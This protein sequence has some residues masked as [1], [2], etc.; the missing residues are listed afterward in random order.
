MVHILLYKDEQSVKIFIFL[1]ITKKILK[2]K[3]ISI[4][5]ASII[6]VLFLVLLSLPLFFENKIIEIGKNEINKQLNG[7]VDFEK[8]KLSFIKNFPN[9]SL[10]LKNVYITG[11]DEFENDTLLAGKDITFVLNLKSIFSKSGYEINKIE[12]RDSKIAAHILQNGKANWD[13]FKSDEEETQDTTESNFQFKIKDFTIKN[14]N[15]DYIDEEGDLA[16]TL[17]NINSS[18]KGDFTSDSTLLSVKINADTLNFW[19]GGAKL[20]HSIKL[21]IESDIN[22]NLKNNFYQFSNNSIQIN[23]IPLSLNGWV[24]MN[25]NDMEMDVRLGTEKVDFKSILSLIPAIY[26]DSFASINADGN[27]KLSGFIAGKYSETLFPNF[28]LNLMVEN[29]RFQYPDLPKSVDNI[30][31]ISH[32][33]NSGNDLDN[34][35]IDVQKF[36]FNMA[37]NPFS[38]SGKIRTPLSDPAFDV[39]AKGTLNLGMIKDIYPLEKGTELNGV[40]KMDL[41]TAGKMSYIEQ[42]LYEKFN[43]IGAVNLFNIKLKNSDLSQTVTVKSG[44][45]NFNNRYVILSNFIINSD[46]NDITFNG[47]AENYMA[48]VLRDKTLKGDFSIQS[49]YFNANDFLSSESDADENT[50][51]L[52]VVKIPKNLDIQLLGT[53]K[54][55]IY[56]KM[57]FKNAE[58]NLKVKDGNVAI[59]KMNL[60]G[61]GGNLALSGNYKT[62]NVEQPKIDFNIALNEISFTDLFKQIPSLQSILPIFEKMTGK[63]NSKL[64]FTSNLQNDMMPVLTSIISNGSLSTTSVGLKDMKIF[65]ELSGLLKIKDLNQ[66]ILK[67]IALHFTIKDGN[68]TTKP[69]DI[70]VGDYK[71]NLGGSTGLDQSINYLGAIKLPEK[72]NVG[73]FQTIGFEIGGTFKKP[74]IKLDV[75]NTL[76]N[77]VD[78]E[79]TKL[80]EKL[81]DAKNQL[82]DKGKQARDNALEEA[83]KKADELLLQAKLQGEKLIQIAKNQSDSLV[84]KTNNPIAKELAKKGGAEL[85]KQAQKQADNLNKQA[86]DEADKLLKKAESSTNI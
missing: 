48:Y 20:A 74:A 39:A 71:L 22:A 27:V 79:K 52:S 82:V 6:L 25:E 2:M 11:V 7:K 31:I 72:L 81:D 53:M 85:I 46:K 3:K 59:E 69:F 62:E 65:S 16:A 63:F 23:A 24:Q 64:S 66:Q 38:V 21:N 51:Q 5:I 60:D 58:L 61:M 73:K 10:N 18:I 56:S 78:E 50:T 14:L 1:Q 17:R 41:K 77:I 44:D 29:G 37:E 4:V 33:K 76:Q 86:K 26:N 19:N 9:A 49:N 68:V 8:I 80:T 55:L 35:E 67:N 47:K 15:V 28:D 54:E 36:N 57:N 83:Q 34:T 84:A 12:I 30:Q 45:L 43:F 13:I 32:I 42:N 70:S 40:I 75:K